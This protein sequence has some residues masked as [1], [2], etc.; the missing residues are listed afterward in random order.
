MNVTAIVGTSEHEQPRFESASTRRLGAQLAVA[1]PVTESERG[2]RMHSSPRSWL[3]P[4][5]LSRDKG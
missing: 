1:Q 5:E 3:R 2:A 4:V